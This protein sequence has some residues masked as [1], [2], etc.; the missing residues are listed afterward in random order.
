MVL[1]DFLFSV[2]FLQ[3]TSLIF[4]AITA[5]DGSLEPPSEGTDRAFAAPK[6]AVGTK[7]LP[8]WE[9]PYGPAFHS[10]F[11]TTAVLPYTSLGGVIDAEKIALKCKPAKLTHC[12]YHVLICL[13]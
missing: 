3:A 7:A 9:C 8:L 12:T 13:W 4:K 1:I 11:L 2:S 5:V 6:G 10:T